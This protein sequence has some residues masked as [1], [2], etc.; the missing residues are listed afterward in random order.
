MV[1]GESLRPVVVGIVVGLPLAF[2]AGRVSEGLLFGINAADVATYAVAVTTVLLAATSASL[3]PAMRAA[4]VDPLVAL[5]S[6]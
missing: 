1:F 4:S 5:R 6:E 3:V 2:A